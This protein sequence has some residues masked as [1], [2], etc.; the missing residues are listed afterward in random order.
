MSRRGERVRFAY[1]DPP[2]LGQA[3][4]RYG[5]ATYDSPDAHRALIHKLYWEYDAFAY[6]LSSSNLY[7]VLPWFRNDVRI[8][9]WVKPFASFKPN[10]NPAYAWEPVLWHSPTCRQREEPTVRDWVSANITLKQGTHGAKPPQFWHWLFCLV[11]LRPGDEFYDL[12]P[13]SGGGAKAW[14]RYRNAPQLWAGRAGVT[15]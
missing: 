5:D 9:A 14:E 8:G 15:A 12:F 1:A 13:G 3:L 4:K 6:S 10:V 7:Q 2:Y 11:G